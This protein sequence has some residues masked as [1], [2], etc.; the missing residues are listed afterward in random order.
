[1]VAGD[2]DFGQAREVEPT[3]YHHCPVVFLEVML[4]MRMFEMEVVLDV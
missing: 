4:G 1:V 2:E 3:V